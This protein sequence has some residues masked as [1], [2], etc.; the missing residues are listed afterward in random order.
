MFHCHCKNLDGVSN[1]PVWKG[2]H[3]CLESGWL[4]TLAWNG[5]FNCTMHSPID[6]VLFYSVF[7]TFHRKNDSSVVLMS[8]KPEVS[9]GSYLCDVY[10]YLNY[11]SVSF[12]WT[13]M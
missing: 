1:K 11:L 2:V 13:K 9:L 10:R 12:L 6:N 4:I 5:D 8:L 3:I 7:H